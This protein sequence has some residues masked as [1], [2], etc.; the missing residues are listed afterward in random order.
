MRSAVIGLR[1]CGIADEPFWPR[2]ERLLGLA[3]LGALQ[4]ADLERERSSDA[5]DEASAQRSSAWR[6]RG[7]ICVAAAQASS[8]SR[9][10]TIRSTSRAR[11]RVRADGA[12]EL[13]HAHTLERSLE[14]D[15]VAV[16][17]KRPAA[18]ASGRTSS[19]RR[20]CRASGP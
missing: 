9:S 8:P 20:G 12:R 13:A 4:V 3:H 17:L 18:R 16:E 15:A 10:Q 7:M 11:R 2:R 1:L 14:S 19:V 5:A 6:S